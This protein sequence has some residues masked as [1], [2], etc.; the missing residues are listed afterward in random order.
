M[1]QGSIPVWLLLLILLLPRCCCCCPLC[2]V[3]DAHHLA[4][5]SLAR[6]PSTLLTLDQHLQATNAGQLASIARL[7]K[8]LSAGEAGAAPQLGC[9]VLA[10]H[11]QGRAF[12]RTRGCRSGAA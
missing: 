3:Q 11:A 7:G 12:H 10:A 6:K 9:N 4:S 5:F 1:P 8:Q 2:C